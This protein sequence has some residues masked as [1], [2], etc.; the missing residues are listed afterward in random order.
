M[1]FAHTV[2]IAA[3]RALVFAVLTDVARW[4]EWTPSV[5]SARL[6]G[7]GPLGVGSRVLVRQ[8][9]LP[10]VEWEVTDLDPERGFTW[11]A[12]A[13]GVRTVGSH[14][15]EPHGAG[16]RVRLRLAQTGPLGVVIGGLT[17]GLTRRYVRLEGEGLRRHCE[18]A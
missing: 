5:T 11:V 9:R 13:P 18:M 8:P 6:L 4:P 3:C 2:D 7:P 1:E 14:D 12:T 17:R 15:L 10:A 16:T